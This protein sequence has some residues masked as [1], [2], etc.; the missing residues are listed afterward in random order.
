MWKSL[1]HDKRGN[2]NFA[3]KTKTNIWL[4]DSGNW[5]P[6]LVTDWSC[7]RES[8]RMQHLMIYNYRYWEFSFCILVEGYWFIAIYML[9]LLPFLFLFQPISYFFVA[10]EYLISLFMIKKKIKLEL[11]VFLLWFSIELKMTIFWQVFI[12]AGKSFSWCNFLTNWTCD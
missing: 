6:T 2:W 8:E 7:R 1:K 12:I 9:Y 11:A 5:N 4:F 10:C 3:C